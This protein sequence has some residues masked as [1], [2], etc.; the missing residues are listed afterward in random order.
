[1]DSVYTHMLVPVTAA[2]LMN[3]LIF[4]QKW[5]IAKYEKKSNPYIPPGGIVGAIWLIL[6]AILGFVH[7]KLYMLNHKK[8]SIACI[9][10]ILFFLY[11]LAYPL[12]TSFS[13]NPN[14]FFLL[15][16]GALLFALVVAAQVY[17]EDS[18]LLPYTVPLLAWTTY[19]NIVTVMF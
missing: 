9:T 1:M 6:F 2:V 17:R 10:I 19:V 13:T 7:Y 8:V 14:A 16:L 3:G 5:K 18:S 12:I 4:S 11:S 15:N